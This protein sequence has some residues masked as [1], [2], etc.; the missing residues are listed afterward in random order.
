MHLFDL[1][2]LFI[3]PRLTP[4]Y[5]SEGLLWTKTNIILEASVKWLRIEM[6]Y[7]VFIVALWAYPM[8]FIEDL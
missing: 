3:F 8:A 2:L 4:T 5:T 1:R 6:D 7:V